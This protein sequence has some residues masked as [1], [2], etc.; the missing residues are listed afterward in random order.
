[1]SLW[2]CAA[3]GHTFAA[4]WHLYS[5]NGTGWAC[6]S[7]SRMPQSLVSWRLSLSCGSVYA[8]APCYP[9]DLGRAILSGSGKLS[10]P[11]ASGFEGCSIPTS[12]LLQ[13][14]VS[15]ARS[16]PC[17]N[18][19]MLLLWSVSILRRG[20]GGWCGKASLSNSGSVGS[21]C[22]L[23]VP[24]VWARLTAAFLPCMGFARRQRI[25]RMVTSGCCLPRLCWALLNRRLQPARGRAYLSHPIQPTISAKLSKIQNT[26]ACRGC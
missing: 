23:S 19:A 1:V 16:K 15:V 7:H 26:T 12:H 8:Y 6:S 11:A 13:K 24:E 18:G 21:R 9:T 20:V 22:H 10:M 17:Y 2:S 14:A 4:G 25:G 3:L 5:G